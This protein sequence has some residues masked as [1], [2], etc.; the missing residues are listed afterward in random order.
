MMGMLLVCGALVGID[1]SDLQL[2][3]LQQHRDA[4][5]FKQVEKICRSYRRLAATETGPD[6][7]FEKEC[8]SHDR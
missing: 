2:K 6:A 4:G 8:A 7:R 5:R 3:S 1:C